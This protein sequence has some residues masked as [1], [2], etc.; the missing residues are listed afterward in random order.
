MSD[1][2]SYKPLSHLIAEM[3]TLCRNRSTGMVFI[4]TDDNQ[5]ARLNLN[6]GEIK[7]ISFHN[8][9]GADALALISNIQA[10]RLRFEEGLTAETVTIDLPSTVDIFKFLNNPIG[11][12][13]ASAV[14]SAPKHTG[15]ALSASDRVMIEEVLTEFIGPMACIVC[16]EELN[17]AP[18]LESGLRKLAAEIQESSQIQDF[19]TQVRARLSKPF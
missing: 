16:E 18:D 12:L 10:G 1:V 11:T 17:A 9:R 2:R 4:A 13:S 5:M 14:S 3:E 8:K 19:L 6:A 15:M 7:F